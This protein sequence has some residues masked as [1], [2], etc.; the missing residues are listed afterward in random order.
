MLC[1]YFFLTKLFR[2]MSFIYLSYTFKYFHSHKC[3]K[4][5]RTVTLLKEVIDGGQL[6]DDF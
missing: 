2:L 1:M 3:T 5:G 6:V 4:L